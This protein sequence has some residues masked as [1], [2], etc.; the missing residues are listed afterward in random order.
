[1]ILTGLGFKGGPSGNPV[2]MDLKRFARQH[3]VL[4][5]VAIVLGVGFVAACW[6]LFLVG[7]AAI[8]TVIVVWWVGQQ[9]NRSAQDQWRRLNH[10]PAARADYGHLWTHG[11]STDNNR[12]HSEPLP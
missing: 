9:A 8:G 12:Q 3:P 4:A 11:A 5:G 10:Q 2:S 6:Q 1:M 7:G